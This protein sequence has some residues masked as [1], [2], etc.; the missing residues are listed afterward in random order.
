[1]RITRTITTG[2]RIHSGAHAPV[3]TGMRPSLSKPLQPRKIMFD[4]WPN[5]S[6][7]KNIARPSAPFA[8]PLGDAELWRAEN[9]KKVVEHLTAQSA[10]HPL[11]SHGKNLIW[12]FSTA[13]RCLRDGILSIQEIDMTRRCASLGENFGIRRVS[14]HRRRVM[15]IFAK[16]SAKTQGHDTRHAHESPTQEAWKTPEIR[17]ETEFDDASRVSQVESIIRYEFKQKAL[18]LEALTPKLD[19]HN[20]AATN[21]ERLVLLGERII[22]LYVG[23][24]WWESKLP[25][26]FGR[27]WSAQLATGPRLGN[28][29]K[30][31]GLDKYLLKPYHEYKSMSQMVAEAVQS[32]IG[33][34]Y[35]DCDRDFRVIEG[36]MEILG[37][38]NYLRVEAINVKKGISL[39]Q[40]SGID[41]PEPVE[42]LIEISRDDRQAVQCA[43]KPFETKLPAASSVTGDDLGKTEHQ[44]TIPE[45]VPAQARCVERAM[46]ISK[47]IEKLSKVELRNLESWA[48]QKGYSIERELEEILEVWSALTANIQSLKIKLEKD[49]H[50]KQAPAWNESLA[51]LPISLHIYESKLP[52]MFSRFDEMI[53]YPDERN[54]LQRYRKDLANATKADQLPVEVKESN[55]AAPGNSVAN[56]IKQKATNKKVAMDEH[57]AHRSTGEPGLQ[58][59]AAGKLRNKTTSDRETKTQ[60]VPR[61]SFVRNNMSKKVQKSNTKDDL[62]AGS[63]QQRF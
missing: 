12:W 22:S 54:F 57:E 14:S 16:H 8:K 27:F 25:S 44:N 60:N 63:S 36:L 41:K 61:E 62:A 29:G 23:N 50:S 58:N 39:R 24:F 4:T 32:I 43:V 47:Q 56:S 11:D 26:F 10:E 18:C 42:A 35:L 20:A 6:N 31:L 40:Q 15:R 49:P 3:V 38:K 17:S 45:F 37:L 30:N 21:N 28:R 59:T 19:A 33:A 46:F 13:E 52:T 7:F 2:G 55:L 48:G 51:E 53:L 34:V 1:M 9:Y 5:S